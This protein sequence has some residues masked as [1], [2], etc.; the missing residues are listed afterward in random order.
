M[1]APVPVLY[2]Y[3]SG[4][5]TQPPERTLMSSTGEAH[6]ILYDANATY[7]LPYGAVIDVLINNTDGGEHPIHFHGHAFWVI[8]TSV[9]EEAENLFSHNWVRRDVVSVPA[10][11]WAKIRFVADNPGVWVT[12]CHIGEWPRCRKV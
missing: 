1:D 9:F 6:G 8:A 3:L 7:Y 2:N 12:H 5:T 4:A 11:G 10:Q